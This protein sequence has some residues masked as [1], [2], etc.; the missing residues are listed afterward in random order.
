MS[1]GSPQ[2]SP[3][4]D[5]PV[6]GKSVDRD[7]EP[8]NRNKAEKQDIT[9]EVDNSEPSDVSKKI[10]SESTQVRQSSDEELLLMHELE[11]DDELEDFGESPQPGSSAAS[12]TIR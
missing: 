6:S 7:I 12:S 1:G 10:S 3:A 2:S 9:K 8:N 4:K 5:S 11:D